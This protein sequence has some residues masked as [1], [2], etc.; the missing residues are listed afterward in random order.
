M[1]QKMRTYRQ[2]YD[3]KNII[4]KVLRNKMLSLYTVEVKGKL[5]PLPN[6]NMI[7][8]KKV[9]TEFGCTIATMKFSEKPPYEK[10]KNILNQM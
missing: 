4:K 3:I 2:K 7:A 10:L 1:I 5:R 8:F 9:F 6:V